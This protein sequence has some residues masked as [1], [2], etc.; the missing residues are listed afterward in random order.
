MNITVQSLVGMDTLSSAHAGALVQPCY[1]TLMY[2]AMQVRWSKRMLHSPATCISET[3]TRYENDA[4]RP[5]AC[6]FDKIIEQ[7]QGFWSNW[8]GACLG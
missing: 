2:N 5:R 6:A 4:T 8:D 1:Y 7:N 3:Q